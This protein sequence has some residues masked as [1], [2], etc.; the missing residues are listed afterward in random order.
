MVRGAEEVQRRGRRGCG[1]AEEVHGR[2]RGP[3]RRALAARGSRGGAG[4]ATSQTRGP[5]GKSRRPGGGACEGSCGGLGP[6]QRSWAPA[7]AEAEA[8]EAA[9]SPASRAQALGTSWR[10]DLGRCEHGWNGRSHA[11]P[12]RPS[13]SAMQPSAS[14]HG[15]TQSVRTAPASSG[16]WVTARTESSVSAIESS[17]GAVLRT[18]RGRRGQGGGG[19]GYGLCSKGKRAVGGKGVR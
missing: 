12:R 9:T 3:G 13:A 5:G 10:A 16:G 1:G 2:G 11:A 19:Q 7:E 17:S 8:A 15:T 14:A 18:W 6:Q 4:G